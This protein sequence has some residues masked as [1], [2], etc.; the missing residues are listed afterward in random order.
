MRRKSVLKRIIAVMIFLSVQTLPTNT[1][2]ANSL[3]NNTYTTT[4]TP[5][6]AGWQQAM[7]QSFSIKNAEKTEFNVIEKT[8][9]SL[10]GKQMSLYSEYLLLQRNTTK[11]PESLQRTY[12]EKM[13]K[14]SQKLITNLRKT[15][16]SSAAKDGKHLA[17]ISKNEHTLK[18]LFLLD[19]KAVSTR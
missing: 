15:L 1:I 8:L 4:L 10:A 11:S 13:L 2:F 16:I 18:A 12:A 14:A 9:A 5:G 17:R 19:R 3:I 6:N 7:P